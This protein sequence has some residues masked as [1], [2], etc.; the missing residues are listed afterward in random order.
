MISIESLKPHPRN[1]RLAYRE[2][3]IAGIASNLNGEMLPDYALRVR[4]VADGF[5]IVSGHHRWQAGL[6][7]GLTELP[8]WVRELSDD[9][10][11]MALVTDNG[12]GEL[13]PLEIGKHAFGIPKGNKWTGPKGKDYAEAIGKDASF[14]TRVKG[15]YE[16]LEFVKLPHGNLTDPYR[17]LYEI[18]AMPRATWPGMVAWLLEPRDDGLTVKAV[19]AAVQKARDFLEAP[20]IEDN[21]RKWLDLNEVALRIGTGKMTTSDVA[22]LQR[23]AREIRDWL[24]VELERLREKLEAIDAMIRPALPDFMGDFE[25]WLLE[26]PSSWSAREVRRWRDETSDKLQQLEEEIDGAKGKMYWLMNCDFRKADIAPETVDVIIT[27][28]PYPKEFMGL[29]DGL[30]EFA[31]RVLKPG[32]S[33][34]VMVGNLYEDEVKATLARHLNKKPTC[35]Y[36]TPGGQAVQ[37]MG[38]KMQSFHKPLLWFAKGEYKGN[39]IGSVFRSDVNDNDKEHHHWGQS[40]SGMGRI[41]EAFSERGQLVLDPFLGGGTTGIVAVD[42]G[43]KFIGVDI[44]AKCIK[45]TEGRLSDES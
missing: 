24:P 19:Q 26:S 32:G 3:V 11:Y 34:V 15:A 12:Q 33:L 13:S 1:P 31:A 37:L 40:E 29:F 5:E 28:P 8:C 35:V 16:V 25:A 2:D 36:L 9:E 18:R 22:K 38:E 4:P 20:E 23:T 30:G 27:D 14:L 43:R 44:D 17:H 45:D 39:W 6:R 10:A 41:V 42:L 21:N 7:K